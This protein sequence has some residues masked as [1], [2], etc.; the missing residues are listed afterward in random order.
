MPSCLGRALRLPYLTTIPWSGN[1][2]TKLARN[3]RLKGQKRAGGHGTNKRP[4]E[5]GSDLWG[6]VFLDK[7]SELAGCELKELT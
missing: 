5:I 1:R 3:E 6:L 2:E 7:V 4:T